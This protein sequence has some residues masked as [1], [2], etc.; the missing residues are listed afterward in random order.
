MLRK[1][2]RAILAL[3]ALALIVF[4][5]MLAW[6][7]DT[8]KRTMLGG[9][10]THETVPPQVPADLKRPAILVFSK[11]NGFRHEEAI[12]AANAMFDAMAAE[13]GWGL[14]KTENGAVM[15]PEILALFDAVVFSNA[16]GDMFTPQQ[17]AAFKA[18]L[19]NGGGYLGIHAAGDSSHKEWG[20]YVSEV[21]GT[22]FIGHPID[23]QF[24]KATVRIEDRS[25]PA[26]RHLGET[27]Q[28]TDEWYSFDKP[29]RKPGIT[30][31]ATLDETTYKPGSLMGTELAMGKDHPIVW[32]RCVGKGRAFYSALGHTAASFSEPEYK[33]LLAGA[34]DWVLRKD[35][36]GCGES[37]AAEAKK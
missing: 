12:P 25:H 15:T 26:T 35:G 23:P 33:Q 20:W 6:N 22:N 30:V 24:Q 32:W 3:I 2:V 7:W 9:Y 19:E 31:L 16:S 13:R 29:P 21:I 14:F 18:F 28:R 10:H 5:A 36:E 37:P 17:E 27:W 34:L 1:L 8:V 11:T 4:A